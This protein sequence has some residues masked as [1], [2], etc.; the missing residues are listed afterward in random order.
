MKNYSIDESSNQHG[1]QEIDSPRKGF[2]CWWLVALA[3]AL[4]IA[5]IVF[6]GRNTLLRA[7][8]FAQANELLQIE[9]AVANYKIHHGSAP[10]SC[11]AEDV[12][13]H[14]ESLFGIT[15]EMPPEIQSLDEAETLAF[16]LSGGC[17]RIF[18]EN[19][20]DVEVFYDIDDAR[21][22][23]RDGDGFLEYNDDW[24]NTYI[25]RNGK[26][27]IIDADGETVRSLDDPDLSRKAG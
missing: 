14:L 3:S 19:L 17:R 27:L 8:E 26:P 5:F 10:P 4:L 18:P 15:K 12:A 11:D 2:G 6:V 16:W 24:G 9:T 7:R 25:F 13:T 1:R 20:A 22:T 21:T 23:D